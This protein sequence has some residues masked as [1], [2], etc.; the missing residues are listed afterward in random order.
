MDDR[1]NGIMYDIYCFT[2]S[3]FLFTNRH[4]IFGKFLKF[5][6]GDNE[7]VLDNLTSDRVQYFIS[8]NTVSDFITYIRIV[9]R[10]EG[11]TIPFIVNDIPNVMFRNDHIRKKITSA[12]GDK[13]TYNSDKTAREI[14]GIEDNSW[15]RIM[16]DNTTYQ[17]LDRIIKGS[18][19][20]TTI[21]NELKSK[22]QLD[23]ILSSKELEI[24]K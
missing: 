14:T 24:F 2:K 16:L 15:T 21:K 18:S 12:I 7:R 3:M 4:P 22:L 23:Y 20:E 6:V 19:I 8:A 13:K 9:M 5:F 17:K 1:I 11:L 10:A